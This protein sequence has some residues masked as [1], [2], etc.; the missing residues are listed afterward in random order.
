MSISDV[1]D[2]CRKLAEK[3]EA[4]SRLKAHNDMNVTEVQKELSSYRTEYSRDKQTLETNLTQA[5]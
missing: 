2:L 3:D 5:K 1:Q 4:L